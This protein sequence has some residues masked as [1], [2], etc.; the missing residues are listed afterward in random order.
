MRGFIFWTHLAL[1][2]AAGL[3]ILVMSVTGVCLAFETQLTGWAERD[4][5]SV[6]PPAANA[7]RLGLDEL[8]AKV[9]AENPAATPG[10]VTLNAAPAASVLVNWGGEEVAYVNPYT[11]EILGHGSRVRGWLQK[12]EGWHRWLGVSLAH[13]AGGRAV[14]GAANLIFL[15]LAVSGLYLWWP[16]R[17]QW[18]ALR[19]SVWFVR[20]LNGRAR[21]WNWHNAVGCWC[22]PVLIVLTLTGVV[23][24]YPWAN[25][26]LYTLTGNPPPPANQSNAARRENGRRGETD[27]SAA[28]KKSPTLASL[29]VMLAKV[30]Q[31]APAWKTIVLRLP[32]RS[33][34]PVVATVQSAGAQPAFARS[35]MTL[36]ART[37]EVVKWEPFAGQNLGRKL[38][39]WARFLH[40]GEAGGTIG[41]ALAALASAGGAAL[42]VTGLFMAWRRFFG[43]NLTQTI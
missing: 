16:R 32:Q 41:R 36:D 22:A 25:N 1:G 26:L 18:R 6:T 8:L 34:A 17:W 13:R 43:K 11:G 28:A 38:R 2:V 9:R 35:Q 10:A 37:G 7:P 21:D 27:D 33:G 29:E 30:E 4:L 5:R 19:P 42:V 15:L 39:I 3:I 14:T 23:M 12:I 40:T 24:S 20:G 31:Q